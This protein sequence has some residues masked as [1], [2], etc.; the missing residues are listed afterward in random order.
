[1][2][3]GQ[4]IKMVMIQAGEDIEDTDEYREMIAIYINEG[5]RRMLEKYQP[6]RTATLYADG[7]RIDLAAVRGLERVKRV[8]MNESGRDARYSAAGNGTIAVSGG[9]EAAYDVEYTYEAE[10]M[11]DETDE[12]KLP[13]GAHMALADYA[14]WRFYSN[15]NIAKQQRGQF[16]YQRF[17]TELERLKP[18]NQ[19]GGGLRN[20]HGLYDV[21]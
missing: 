5:Y 14:T 1:M 6:T 17:H 7:G 13:A 8:R 21:T 2:K 19:R 9:N 11:K 12:P 20:F 15:G 4:I 10:E 3:L 16:Y 18:H